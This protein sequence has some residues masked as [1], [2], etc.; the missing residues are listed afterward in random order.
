MNCT[1]I[2]FVQA[3]H[4]KLSFRLG[5]CGFGHIY[6][7]K[8]LM[9]NFIFCAVQFSIIGLDFLPEDLSFGSNMSEP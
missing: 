2:G 7:R 3:Q 8:F 5:N 9:Q 6:W 4:K 1:T